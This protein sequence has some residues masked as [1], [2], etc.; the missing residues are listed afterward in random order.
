MGFGL[1]FMTLPGLPVFVV[2]VVRVE[3]RALF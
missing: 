2:Q 3:F 1:M